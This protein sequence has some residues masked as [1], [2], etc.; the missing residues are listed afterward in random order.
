[1]INALKHRLVIHHAILRLRRIGIHFQPYFL[2][3]EGVRPHAA[4]WPELALEFPSSVLN[5][6]DTTDVASI[7]AFDSWRTVEHVHARLEKGHLCIL[8]KNNGR[9]A[10]FTWADLDE[11]NDSVCDYGLRP[12][13]TYLYDAFT[14]PQFRGRNLAAYMRVESYN[15]LRRIGRNTFYSISECFNTPAIKFK[16]RL[17]ADRARLYLQI[18]I[19]RRVLGHWELKDYDRRRT[20]AAASPTR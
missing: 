7:A 13:E 11:V 1:M 9:I 19:G 12:G 17:N 3:R 2:F 6:A 18:K 20:K 15:H 8:L 16:E 4:A 10:G 5:A 14:A